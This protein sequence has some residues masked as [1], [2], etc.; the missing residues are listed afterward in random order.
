M[1]DS[2]LLLALKT[3]WTRR[4]IINLSPGEFSHYMTHLC[5]ERDE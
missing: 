2:I 4:E 1:L 3:G 5:K